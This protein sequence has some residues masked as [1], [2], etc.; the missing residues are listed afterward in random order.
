MP[1]KQEV[2]GKKAERT[3]EQKSQEEKTE[4]WERREENG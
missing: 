1:K 4:S 2:R 3:K